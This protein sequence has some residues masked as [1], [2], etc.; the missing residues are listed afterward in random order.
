MKRSASGDNAGNG[1]DA[2]SASLD[3]A[4]EKYAPSRFPTGSGSLKLSV[5][6]DAVRGIL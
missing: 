1:S 3:P 2:G 5:V 4:Y 6:K